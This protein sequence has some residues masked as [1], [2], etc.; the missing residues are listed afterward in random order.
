MR[1]MRSPRRSREAKEGGVKAHRFFGQYIA[2]AVIKIKANMKK[3]R[4]FDS[5]EYTWDQIDQ[6]HDVIVVVRLKP[7]RRK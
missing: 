5:M 4:W 3:S 1:A 6:D 7:K 2:E